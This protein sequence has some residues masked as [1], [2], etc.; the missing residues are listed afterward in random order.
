MPIIN[1]DQQYTWRYASETFDR[2]LV[3]PNPT[4]QGAYLVT[5]FEVGAR[6]QQEWTHDLFT[7][8]SLRPSVPVPAG[9]AVVLAVTNRSVHP[10]DYEPDMVDG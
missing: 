2:R 1:P 10:L 7:L 4:K 6:R 5:R 3:L 8:A 9:S